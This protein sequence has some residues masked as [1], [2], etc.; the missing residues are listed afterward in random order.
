[1]I[2]RFAN[3]L[4]KTFNSGETLGRMGGDEFIVIVTDAYGYNA[5][6]KTTALKTYIDEDN[7]GND[8]KVSTSYGYCASTEL[9][10]PTAL[11]VY[12]E[13]DKRMYKN[14]EEYYKKTGKNRR[15]NDTQN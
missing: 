6:E 5:E 9:K 3:M 14:K 1:M 13:A 8:I 10:A 7:E 4:R 11:A 2:V 12:K 15:R